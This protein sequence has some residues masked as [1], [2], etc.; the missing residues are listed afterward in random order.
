MFT[1]SPE[2]NARL[3]KPFRP[4]SATLKQI[5]DAVPKELLEKNTLLSTAF[6]V[7]DIV[8]CSALFTFAAYIPSISRWATLTLLP[9]DTQPVVT[10]LLWLTYWW[11]QGLVFTSFFC[12]AHELGHHA[13][14]DNWW[15]NNVLGFLFD[16]FILVPF[17][18]WKA[19]HNA[20]HKATGSIERDENYVPHQRSHYKL[21]PDHQIHRMDY[22]E[23]FDDT[24]IFTLGR[25]IVMQVF[26]WWLYLGYNAMGSPMYPQGTN[27]ISPYSPLFRADQR[28]GIIISDFGLSVMLYLLAYTASHYGWAKVLSFYVVPYLI[29]NH[30]IVLCTFLH[31]SDPTIPHYRQQEWTFLR[32]AAATVDRPILG[33][34]GRFFFHNVSHDHVA[35]HFFSAAPFYNQPKITEAIRQVLGND[36][37]YDSTCSIYA[38]YRSFTQCLFIEDEGDIVFY[39]N[40]K[41]QA[42]RVVSE[43]FLQKDVACIEGRV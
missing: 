14:Y 1:N 11:W 10:S 6:V 7:R 8:L 39:K 36:Y 17:F 38:L 20:H 19:S 13:L 26:G 3:R 43:E 31:H 29:C 15:A 2:Y 22:M 32:G 25:L 42:Q 23:V 24:P 5:H 9:S 12:I 33:W 41:G 37:N 18:A 16:T 40:A 30:W 4:P 21:P 27:H 28:K 35:H 34:M